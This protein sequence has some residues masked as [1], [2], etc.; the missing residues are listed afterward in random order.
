M[1]V[2]LVGNP[3]AAF[4]F[5]LNLRG[6]QVSR[7]DPGFKISFHPRVFRPDPRVFTPQ[8]AGFSTRPASL[9][10][11]CRGF[12]NQHSGFSHLEPR[13]FL[14]RTCFFFDPTIGFSSEGRIS[15]LLRTVPFRGR[16]PRR[17]ID[18]QLA[19]FRPSPRRQH[20]LA[21]RTFLSWLPAHAS[22]I[23]RIQV[24][25]FLQ[26]LFDEVGLWTLVSSCRVLAHIEP[27]GLRVEM[28]GS[29]DNQI[30]MCKTDTKIQPRVSNPGTE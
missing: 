21:W 17:V 26:H 25:E 7:P 22:D 4:S 8:T 14:S 10:A 28:I 16:Y 19:A 13:I 27:S 15:L 2:S 30:I 6:Q 1:R 18:T 29:G 12:S 3:C 20:V 5:L 11:P 9:H 24:L 23:F